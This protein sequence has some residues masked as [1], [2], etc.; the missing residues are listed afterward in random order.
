MV[1]AGKQIRDNL[2]DDYPLA[3]KRPG[4]VDTFSDMEPAMITVDEGAKP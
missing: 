3:F 2:L 4:D 1:E